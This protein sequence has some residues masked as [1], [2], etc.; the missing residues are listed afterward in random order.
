MAMQDHE[1]DAYLGDGWT[2][3]QRQKIADDW[4]DFERANPG[5]SQEEQGAAMLTAICQLHDGVLEIPH[6]NTVRAAVIASI[7]Y[8][9]MSESEAARRAGIDRGT[10]RRWIG[11]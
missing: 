7:R 8:G 6:A 10:V 2:S 4:R 5:A 11:K 9:G 3:E 1:L